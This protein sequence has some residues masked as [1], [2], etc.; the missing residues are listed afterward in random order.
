MIFLDLNMPIMDGKEACKQIIQIYKE[1]NEQQKRKSPSKGSRSEKQ[2][3]LIGDQ[4]INSDIA[5]EIGYCPLLVASSAY[6][7]N[8]IR[9]ECDQIGF[10][11]CADVPV[12]KEFLTQIFEEI[13]ARV[14]HCKER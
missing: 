14:A 5:A 10:D 1:L 12:G 13:E 4:R 8:Q 7:T 2:V 11:H 9:E 3:V 6:M